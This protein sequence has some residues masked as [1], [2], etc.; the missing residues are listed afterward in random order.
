MTVHHEH[1]RLL[2][3]NDVQASNVMVTIPATGKAYN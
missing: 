2:S 1:A 3:L